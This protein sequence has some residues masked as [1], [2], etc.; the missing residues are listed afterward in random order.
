MHFFLK[1]EIKQV[2]LITQVSYLSASTRSPRPFGG[3]L[4]ALLRLPASVSTPSLL[5][6]CLLPLL[7][8]P[9][10]QRAPAVRTPRGV[11]QH[12]ARPLCR[13]S[14]ESLL[15]ALP[16]DGSMRHSSFVFFPQVHSRRG[17]RACSQP[18]GPAALGAPRIRV[19]A[20]PLPPPVPSRRLGQQIST[21]DASPPPVPGAASRARVAGRERRG[22]G[23]IGSLPAGP[24]RCG[25]AAAARGSD[26]GHGPGERVRWAPHAGRP[27]AAVRR[28]TPH[29][30]NPR[31]G[32][33]SG[34]VPRHAPGLR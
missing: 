8:R 11:H 10:L 28:P 6:C 32:R 25:V 16:L 15:P 2:S 22:A 9:R 29:A 20:P 5:K 27:C 31:A 12:R 26:R 18:R 7:R 19:D 24:L 21:P 34:P 3:A 17:S 4:G 1:N 30:T 13:R 23:S 14:R 33:R